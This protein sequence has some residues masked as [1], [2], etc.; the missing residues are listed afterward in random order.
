MQNAHTAIRPDNGSRLPYHIG[1]EL[2][3]K[4]GEEH[5]ERVEYLEEQAWNAGESLEH[6]QGNLERWL[7]SWDL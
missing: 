2:A 3:L 5:L 4:A 1:Y 7:G 6:V